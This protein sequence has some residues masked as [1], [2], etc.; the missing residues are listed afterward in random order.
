MLS[1]KSI[2]QALVED[3]YSSSEE[4][5]APSPASP[6]IPTLSAPPHA[7]QSAP[8]VSAASA[9]SSTESPSTCSRPASAA[10]I[11]GPA[12]P[13]PALSDQHTTAATR[14]TP[15]TAG[16]DDANL[17]ATSAAGQAQIQQ[18]EQLVASLRQSLSAAVDTETTLRSELEAVQQQQITLI[19]ESRVAQA[20]AAAAHDEL[21][22]A[23]HKC[24]AMQSRIQSLEAAAHMPPQASPTSRADSVYA[25]QLADAEHEIEMLTA[26]TQAVK[27]ELQAWRERCV[28]AEDR[29]AAAT[30]RIRALEDIISGWESAPQAAAAPA[31]AP[32]PTPQPV[33]TPASPEPRS[34]E[35]AQLERQVHQQ[36]LQLIHLQEQLRKQ[37]E[38]TSAATK[39]AV[40]SPQPATAGA[41]PD[42]SVP[43]IAQLV[44]S[45]IQFQAQRR[46]SPA[47]N[48]SLQILASMLP[49][50]PSQREVLDLDQPGGSLGS[51]TELSDAWLAF[52]QEEA[53][54]R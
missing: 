2:V 29:G 8:V 42:T 17:A 5:S 7:V 12:Q 18:L 31:P 32:A 35:L 11:A 10:A 27:S 30:L 48:P 46:G 20:N 36:R 53:K 3:D 15:A 47:Q 49:F 13:S 37:A 28:I 14:H 54:P 1:L 52:L 51:T 6:A 16:S 43:V 22:H 9:A 24:T 33:S 19:A 44:V 26:T 25:A 4:D 23:E 40:S 34:R 41:M 39:A 45:A 50:N 21:Q 38:S